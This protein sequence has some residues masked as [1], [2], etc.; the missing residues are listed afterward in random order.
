MAVVGGGAPGDP[1]DDLILG[2]TGKELPRGLFVPTAQG[3]DAWSVLTFYDGRR[4][5]ADTSQ[6]PPP[7]LRRRADAAAH[8]LP[9]DCRGTG[10]W[11]CGRRPLAI[12]F[13]GTELHQAVSARP[14]ASPH[15]AERAGDEI[16][17]MPLPTRFLG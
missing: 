14:D 1:L 9:P 17:E 3:D 5:R 13:I 10:A 15:R 7:A 4:G 2:L 11:S 8:L 16:V 6:L 12:D